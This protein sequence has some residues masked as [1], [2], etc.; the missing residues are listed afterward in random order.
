MPNV[1]LHKGRLLVDGVDTYM[2]GVNWQPHVLGLKGHE[3]PTANATQEAA[4]DAPTIASAGFNVVKT[5]NFLWDA[6]VIDA[7]YAHGVYTVTGP[8]N[9]GN[10]PEGGND[11]A[12]LRDKV[13]AFKSAPGLLMWVIGNEWIYNYLYSGLDLQ[14]SVDVL[15]EWCRV[16]KEE[17]GTRPVVTVYGDFATHT[18]GTHSEL[19]NCLDGWGYNMYRASFN[20]DT[21]DYDGTSAFLNTLHTDDPEGAEKFRFVGEYGIDAYNAHTSTEVEDQQADAIENMMRELYWSRGWRGG[22]VF[23][24]QDEWSKAGDVTTAAGMTT[25]D[26]GGWTPGQEESGCVGPCIY[27]EDWWGMVRADHTP[28]AAVAR[29]TQT[30]SDLLAA[31]SPPAPPPSLGACCSM[32]A[33]DGGVACGEGLTDVVDRLS[34][35]YTCGAQVSYCTTDSDC[36][37]GYGRSPAC[38]FIG[39]VQATTSGDC[40]ACWATAPPSPPPLPTPPTPPTPPPCLPAIMDEVGATPGFENYTLAGVSVEKAGVGPGFYLFRRNPTHPV[41]LASGT[42]LQ[43]TGDANANW[44]YTIPNDD[45]GDF[46]YYVLYVTTAE[47]LED[48]V[49]GLHPAMKIALTFDDAC[50]SATAP[51]PPSPPTVVGSS[52]QCAFSE[53]IQRFCHGNGLLEN[54]I[55]ANMDDNTGLYG[56]DRAHA[57]CCA[58]CMANPLCYHYALLR[59]TGSG[60]EC[61]IYGS[62][63]VATCEASGEFGNTYT[64]VPFPLPPSP[65]PR[66]PTPPPPPLEPPPPPSPPSPPPP[67]P[68]PPAPPAPPAS[69]P[70]PGVPW[71]AMPNPTGLDD[72]EVPVDGTSTVWTGEH[73][74]M[75]TG[76]IRVRGTMVVESDTRVTTSRIEVEVGG[77]VR[78]GTPESP[79]T[80]VTLYLDHA[81]CESVGTGATEC[82]KR[83]EV[84]IRGDW[85]SYGVPVTAW[86]RLLADCGTGCAELQVEECRGWA[87]GDELVVTAAR[88]GARADGSPSRRIASLANGT[89]GRDC[90]V[91]IN[92]ALDELHSGAP[93][94]DTGRDSVVRAEVLHFARSIVITGPMHWRNGGI[95]SASSPG[96]GQGIITRAVNDGEVVMHWHHMNNCGRAIL[97][98]YCHHLHHRYQSGGEFKGISV[99]NSVSKAFTIHGTSRARI[100]AA[101]VYNHRGAAIY[102][103]VSPNPSSPTHSTPSTY[104]N[105]QPFRTP[106]ARPHPPPL[107]P[108]SPSLSLPLPPSPS[109]SLPPPRLRRAPKHAHVLTQRCVCVCVCVCTP[110]NG[111]EYN[112]TVIGS[113]IA[114]ESRSSMSNP[115]C[116]LAGGEGSQSNADI[117]E[118]A[119]IYMNSMFSAAI[120]G[121]AISGQD[122]ALFVNNDGKAYGRDVAEGLV[123]PM[124]TRM[125]VHRDNVFHD[126]DGFGWYVNRHSFLQTEIDPVTGFV[127]DWATACQWDFVTGE[128]HAMPGVLENHVEFGNDFGMG[129]YDL[130]DF[131]CRNCSIFQ[132]A[133]GI[134]WKTYRRAKHAGPLLEGGRVYSLS[135]TLHGR[136]ESINSLRLPGGQGLVELKDVEVVGPVKFGFNHHCNLDTQHTGGMCASSY[137]LN[138]VSNPGNWHVAFEEE[139]GGDKD[140]SMIL[141]NGADLQTSET[142]IIG[143]SKRTFDP[144]DV[145]CRPATVARA[146]EAWWCPGTLKIRPMLLFSP[147]RGT[148]HVTSTHASDNDGAP[149]ATPIAPR[150]KV[151]AN[152]VGMGGMYCPPGRNSANG[153]TFLVLDGA[154]LTIDIPEGPSLLNGNVFNDY[155]VMQYSEEQWPA[156]LKSS[157]TVT[158]EGD[159][160]GALAGGPYT[161]HSDHDRS[162]MMPYGAYVSEAGAWWQAKKANGDDMQPWKSVT[163][164]LEVGTY[165]T[166]REG[167]NSG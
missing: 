23:E 133:M 113:A 149:R 34:G 132:S 129:A 94:S 32:C 115:R 24:W 47:E 53:P 85:H 89:D 121:N 148:L 73:L 31:P 139:T 142:L 46:R 58:R 163:G 77:R 11:Y 157:V 30:K 159:G 150:A 138:N 48:L 52:D 101:T 102:F 140:T 117:G 120:I 9:A 147:V 99:L 167:F 116:A 107:P 4:E 69:P 8:A 14:G 28:R 119:G 16:I 136:L 164:F 56:R 6:S 25:Q 18:F 158:V 41:Y 111:A 33:S 17:D 135:H 44:P 29:Y 51:S 19:E 124:A 128:D 145:G 123:A 54:V 87:V 131:T 90:A 15:A 3:I 165:E 98:S 72:C 82:L 27:S 62:Y 130:G 49:C 96:G 35:D 153:Y 125:D 64:K 134:Y 109:L 55:I 78:I 22:F 110:Q 43:P 79:A 95:D 1:T 93:I 68:A 10:F 92:V 74:A 152:G 97:G 71:T 50:P 40:G 81:D 103:E 166:Q 108:P 127:T 80:N 36:G 126:N 105:T 70:L 112:N 75:C 45:T 42:P 13:R 57:L 59:A 39:S 84:L 100:E 5:Y 63:D 141:Q 162:F 118:Q 154:E 122:N 143:T 21:G 114:C 144:D 137:F 26:A 151:A 37:L 160:A 61:W 83:G 7:M 20:M 146:S 156:S 104:S 67:S 12:S 91:G 106:Q 38:Q 76:T 155:F 86:T 66:P 88:V 2:W 65:P 60:D 161:I